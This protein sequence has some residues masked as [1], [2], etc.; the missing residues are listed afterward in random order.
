MWTQNSSKCRAR[1]NNI[2]LHAYCSFTYSSGSVL[3]EHKKIFIYCSF[4]YRA[5]VIR[6]FIILIMDNWGW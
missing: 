6:V 3:C 5:A 4:I 2:L 1:A